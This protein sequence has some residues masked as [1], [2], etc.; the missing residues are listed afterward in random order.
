MDDVAVDMGRAGGGGG[1]GADG[2]ATDVGRADR[3]A[4]GGGAGL[5]RDVGAGGGARFA[6][7]VTCSQMSSGTLLEASG[8]YGEGHMTYLI[9][10]ARLLYK[11]LDELLVVPY[12]AL[13]EPLGGQLFQQSLP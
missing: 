7:S 9:N 4:G 10:P 2:G 1:G 13:A 3:D 8:R 6:G 12:I 11:V 5:R